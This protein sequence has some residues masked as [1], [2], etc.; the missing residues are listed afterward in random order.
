MGI[1]NVQTDDGIK[2]V[3]IEGDKPTDEEQEFILNTFF[4]D[5][6]PQFD[7]SQPSRP[8]PSNIDLATASPEEIENYR[9]QLELAGIN[10]A[11]MQAFEE[12]ET[13]GLKL[14]GVDYDTGVKDFSFR[15]ALGNLELPSE[16]AEYLTRKVGRDGFTVDPGGRFILT[17]VGRQKL[18][19]GD[20]PPISIDEEG[21]SRFD[22]A[23]FIGESGIPLGAGIGAG[24]AMSGFGFLPAAA[25]VGAS[26][27]AGK[28]LDESFE[29]ARGLQKQT[30]NEVLR[31]A[32]MEGAFGIF[33]EGLGRGLSRIF[34]RLIKGPGGQEAE[35][36]RAEGRQLIREG[37]RP[38]LEGAAPNL[39]PIMGR[40]QAIYE[41]VFPNTKAANKNL[42]Q[43]IKELTKFDQ[44]DDV[45]LETLETSI[46]KDISEIYDSVDNKVVNATR[47]LNTEIENSIKAII[48]PLK[49]GEQISQEALSNLVVSK[50][51]FDETA[52]ALFK[53]ASENFSV[54]SKVIPIEQIKKAYDQILTTLPKRE[55]LQDTQLSGILDNAISRAQARGNLGVPQGAPQFLSKQAVLPFTR[56][57]IQEAQTLRKIINNLQYDD[58][59]ALAAKGG[60][61]K[62][63]KAAVEKSFEEA[64]DTLALIVNNIDPVDLG[65]TKGALRSLSDA[66][67]QRIG[68]MLRK[69]GFEFGKDLPPLRPGFPGDFGAQTLRTTV[70]DLAN[71]NKG[72]TDL[73]RAR[74]FYAKGINR[75]DDAVVEKIYAESKKGSLRLDPKRY[76]DQLVK[77]DQPSVLRRFL[78]AVRG[79]PQFKDFDAGQRFLDKQSINIGGR[80][81][82]IKQAEDL[83][84]QFA[85][86]KQKTNLIK[87]IEAAKRKASELS[88]RVGTEQSDAM[89]QSLARAWFER[90]LNDASNLTK[91][92]GIDVLSG[93]KI[94]AKIDGLGTTADELF[95]G[96]SKDVKNLAKLLRQT[97]TEGFD[98]NVL[99]QFG[100]SDMPGLIRGLQQAVKDQAAFKEDSFLRSLQANDAEGIVGQLFKKQN[101]LKVKQFVN[102]NLKVNNIP[103]SEYG[104]INPG[105]VDKVKT[106]ALSKILRSVGD[107]DS[108]AFKDA[109][110]SGR[111]GKR[112]QTVLNDYGVETLDAMLGKETTEGL[113]KLANNMIRVSNQPL[114][115]RGGLSAPNIA[116]GLGLG[117]FLLN[118][119]AT[120]PAAAFYLGMS[121]VLRKPA[122]L[123]LILASRKPGADKLGQAFQVVNSTVAQLGQ[124]AVRS[125]EG[126]FNVPPEISQP[127]QRAI[128]DVS[129]IKI[130]NIQPPANVG[131]AGGV[132]PILVPNPVT[133]ATVGSQ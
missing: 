23:D 52:D 32:A 95:K 99:A 4:A 105:L 58:R 94:A 57:S 14:P 27:F 84:P 126:V 37:F 131:S 123:N 10:P 41:G 42:E 48:E 80:S 81:L 11:T 118:P 125:D 47:R 9:R 46:K 51:S 49:R 50:A 59:L 71:I 82:S 67:G 61:Y 100:R 75:F 85:D 26:M 89:R 90:E 43:V 12:G 7:P 120:L 5:E 132:N 15:T 22:V 77:S 70:G 39:R 96:Y 60:A 64:E 117:A 127:V 40:L 6:A 72:L 17:P 86:G 38:T 124:E 107:V 128:T 36:I 44:I 8:A 133:R 83:L 102:G 101:A 119:L 121:T 24:I 19:L 56:I 109:F 30:S 103:L 111:L 78:F 112:F 55:V 34:G 93:S 31:D 74:E 87:R 122:V 25:V 104:G 18:G 16:K 63:L 92:K 129:N 2:R 1:I 108:P 21:V 114:A 110:I 35:L 53:S 115:G 45:T 76:L 73:R 130:P 116:I 79:S 54:N 13:G 98:E 97:G 65:V 106:A 62:N 29:A 66:E 69:G 3:Q 33:G 28:L 68:E 113:F 88:G 20:G 91:V